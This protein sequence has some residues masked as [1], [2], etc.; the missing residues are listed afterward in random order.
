MS[1]VYVYLVYVLCVCVHACAPGDRKKASSILLY[2]SPLLP[3]RQGL[4]LNLGSSWF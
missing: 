3:S 2:N 1:V 4:S